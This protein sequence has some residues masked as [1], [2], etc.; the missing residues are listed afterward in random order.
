MSHDTMLPAFQMPARVAFCGVDRVAREEVTASFQVG[1]MRRVQTNKTDVAY[2]S[3]LAKY[4]VAQV[5]E[6]RKVGTRLNCRDI[7]SK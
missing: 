4:G 1:F 6:G 7:A 2:P 5:H 3:A